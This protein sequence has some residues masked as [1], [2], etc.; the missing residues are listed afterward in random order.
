M[1]TQNPFPELTHLSG[2]DRVVIRHSDLSEWMR[3]R[4]VVT[5]MRGVPGQL[6]VNLWSAP[7]A[8]FMEWLLS[9]SR[10]NRKG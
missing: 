4:G 5:P 3:V 7:R 9:E 2:P 1:K 10:K 6:I 8:E